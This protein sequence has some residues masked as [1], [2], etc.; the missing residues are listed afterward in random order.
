[1]SK[2]NYDACGFA[3]SALLKDEN[4]DP[5]EIEDLT[6]LREHRFELD[7]P[8]FTLVNMKFFFALSAAT[9]DTDA[10]P[11][12]RQFEATHDGVNAMAAIRAQYESAA[13]QKLRKEDLKP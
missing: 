10:A 3:Q 13:V 8:A 6:E 4:V 7:V 1:M 11:F 2:S 5:D 12:V 9:K